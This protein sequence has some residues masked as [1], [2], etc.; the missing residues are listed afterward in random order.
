MG[1]VCLWICHK[2]WCGFGRQPTRGVQ[3]R[4]SCWGDCYKEGKG[5]SEDLVQAAAWYLKAA[6]QGHA[7]AQR[8][9][10]EHRYYYGEDFAGAAAWFQKAADLGDAD[11]QHWLGTCYQQGEG[12]HKS[13]AHAAAWYQKAAEQGHTKA[14]EDLTNIKRPFWKRIGVRL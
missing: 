6:D 9:L 10:G 14:E 1:W 13:L 12:V 7:A 8:K 2:Q 3:R 11:A 5:V 4:R